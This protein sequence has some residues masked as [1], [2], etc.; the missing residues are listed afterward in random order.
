MF[1]IITHEIVYSSFPEP[2]TNENSEWRVPS[3]YAK[4]RSAN[5]IANVFIDKRAIP[6]C[7]NQI[8]IALRYA[9]QIVKY[10][11]KR[12]WDFK[13]IMKERIENIIWLI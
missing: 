1:Q 13:K 2:K 3:D 11:S 10:F 7:V 9:R 8:R 12:F 6:C 4:H 5:P